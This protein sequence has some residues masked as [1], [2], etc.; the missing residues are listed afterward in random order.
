[1]HHQ[2][3]LSAWTYAI[4]K[5]YQEGKIGDLRYIYASGKG[6]YGGFG[7]M[8]IGT[9]LLT[10]MLKFGGD[11]SGTHK[12]PGGY[13]IPTSCPPTI[14]TNGKRCNRSMRRVS[15]KPPIRFPARAR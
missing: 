15:R 3:R 7:L 8:E 6:Y 5:V 1:M 14:S 2:W 12:A 4:N 10:H 13:P 9:H 11:C